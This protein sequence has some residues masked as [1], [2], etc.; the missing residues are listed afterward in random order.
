MTEHSGPWEYLPVEASVTS[1]RGV[2]CD[3][4]SPEDGPLIAAAPELLDALKD[5]AEVAGNA[6]PGRPCVTYAQRV[7][8]KVE[9]E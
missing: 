2:V 3:A 5:L 7:L 6:W 4:V 9:G 8:A 1:A